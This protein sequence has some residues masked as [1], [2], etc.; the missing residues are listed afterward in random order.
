[1]MASIK[2]TVRRLYALQNERM[3]S[4]RATAS[5][6]VGDQLI[7]SE[8]ISGLTESAV[9]KY[10]HHELPAG[11]PVRVEWQTPG[12]ADMTVTEV[13][14]CPCCRHEPPEL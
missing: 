7:A 12:I 9:S 10:I 5:I 14:I 3:V 2:L 11:Q 8:E 6:Y 1:M 4:T 13:E